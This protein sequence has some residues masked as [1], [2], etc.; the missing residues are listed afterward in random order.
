[1]VAKTSLIK[2][3]KYKFSTFEGSDSSDSSIWAEIWPNSE[4]MNDLFADLMYD[5]ADSEGM[6][7]DEVYFGKLSISFEVSK[8]F[9]DK[10]ECWIFV[11][12]DGNV[13]PMK[14]SL[15]TAWELKQTLLSLWDEDCTELVPLIVRHCYSKL[16]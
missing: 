8:P 9:S 10:E 14:F 16:S 5:I 2:D 7:L 12:Y 1:M 3:I 13:Y 15:K 6:E 11:V 4:Y